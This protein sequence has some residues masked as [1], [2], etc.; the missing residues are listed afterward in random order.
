M[1]DGARCGAATLGSTATPIKRYRPTSQVQL[2]L[3]Y[4]REWTK[5]Y[6]Q[7]FQAN[8]I[9][10]SQSL[11]CPTCRQNRPIRIISSARATA[12]RKVWTE[13]ARTEK[14]LWSIAPD[15]LRRI[16]WNPRP[17]RPPVPRGPE[18]DLRPHQFHC[19]NNP[20]TI[21][22]D[23]KHTRKQRDPLHEPDLKRLFLESPEST[24][25]L[26][27]T[28]ANYD[29]FLEALNLGRFDPAGLYLAPRFYASSRKPARRRRSRR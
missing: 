18:F 15:H 21:R 7:H 16:R 3:N 10:S 23:L 12:Q 1:I 28:W 13:K 14:K 9:I 26:L 11:I 2:W 4:R 24:T 20:V 19:A 5:E 29:A 8:Q 22:L 17:V 27:T 6:F 25:S